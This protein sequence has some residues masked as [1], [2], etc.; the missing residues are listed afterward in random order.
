MDEG[1]KMISQVCVN[2]SVMTEQSILE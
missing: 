2:Y 1:V